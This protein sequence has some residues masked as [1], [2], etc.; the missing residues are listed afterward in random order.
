MTRKQAEAWKVIKKK[1]PD[2]RIDPS[3]SQYDG[4]V[5]FPEKLA[6]ANEHLRNIKLPKLDK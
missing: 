4:K 1:Y 6:R 2:I 3:L 5:L